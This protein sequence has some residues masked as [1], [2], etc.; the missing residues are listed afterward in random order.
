LPALAKWLTAEGWRKP[1]PARAKRCA[2]PTRARNERGKSHSRGGDV[3]LA[4]VGIKPGDKSIVFG[5]YARAAQ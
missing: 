3:A 4:Y 2:R 1:P 5:R